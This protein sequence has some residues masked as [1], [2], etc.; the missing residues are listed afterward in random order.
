MPSLSSTRI[1]VPSLNS[2]WRAGQHVRIRIFSS[3][4]GWLGWTESHPFT[5]ASAPVISSKQG[6]TVGEEGLILICKNAGGWTRKLY[7]MAKKSGYIEAGIADGVDIGKTVA[8]MIEGPYSGPGHAIY[9]SYSGVVMMV[10][11]SGITF[12]LSIIQ[13]LVQKDLQAQSRVK[14]LELIWVVPSPDAMVPLMP[15]FTALVESCASLSISVHYTRA[16]A[17]RPNKSANGSKV[18]DRRGRVPSNNSEQQPLFPVIP[19]GLR[20]SLSAGCPSQADLAGAVEG[21]ITRTVSIGSGARGHEDERGINGVL[22]GVCGPAGLGVQANLA[23]NSIDSARKQQA[24]GVDVYEEYV[25]LLALFGRFI[26]IANAGCLD[27]DFWLR[28]GFT[29]FFIACGN[30]AAR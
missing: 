17:P 23:V 27:G 16:Y 13:D 30:W 6:R 1:E 4:L 25:F 3:S 19:Q 11:G 10:G 24:G 18:E 21:A 20:I 2:G 5:I 22:V 14:V 29:S 28:L 9:A 12:A 8:V 26:L 15:L 7:D